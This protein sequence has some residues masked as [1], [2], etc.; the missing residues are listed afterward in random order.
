[1]VLDPGYF[2]IQSIL[3]IMINRK[4]RLIVFEGIDGA[5]KSTQAQLLYQY[6]KDKGCKVV[7]SREPTDGQ[8]GRRI[9]E[10]SK[11]GIR[12]LPPQKEYE[13]F[14]NDRKEHVSKLIKPNLSKGIHVILDRYYFSTMAYQGA[15]GIDPE[16]IR[17]EN[18]SFAPI[19]DIVFILKLS[20][21]MGLERIKRLRK[22][23]FTM[24]EKKDELKKVS[25][26]FDNMKGDIFFHL[27]AS[28][29]I[30]AIHKEVLKTVWQVIS[31]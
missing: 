25:D 7:L 16:K 20:V 1:M 10:L 17:A 11:N 28:K 14:L 8:Y 21:N 5:G 30:S 29:D 13:L 27:D 24:F 6:L 3:V 4:G 22:Q 19:P 31:C 18:E 12:T 26:I 15:L 2:Q 23:S 9:R